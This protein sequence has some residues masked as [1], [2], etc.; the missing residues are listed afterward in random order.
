[1]NNIEICKLNIIFLNLFGPT[2]KKIRLNQTTYKLNSPIT[3][4]VILIVARF[5]QRITHWRSLK[6][7]KPQRLFLPIFRKKNRTYSRKNIIA[8]YWPITETVLFAFKSVQLFLENYEWMAKMSQANTDIVKF[9]YP[10][11]DFHRI[12]G[13]IIL[14][15]S[16][17]GLWNFV[18]LSLW[19]PSTL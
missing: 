8:E 19:T 3:N 5:K 18:V 10:W 9:W 1:M 2:V 11:E 6:I 4:D 15:F 13:S 14:S 12:G 17:A 16:N 7:M